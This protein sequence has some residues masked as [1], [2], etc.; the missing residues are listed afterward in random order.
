VIEI[1]DEKLLYQ[2]ANNLVV[3]GSIYLLF[4][5][6][7]CVLQGCIILLPVLFHTMHELEESEQDDPIMP[8]KWIYHKNSDLNEVLNYIRNVYDGFRIED[9]IDEHHNLS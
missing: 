5:S 4:Q 2:I 1:L 7:A 3:N 9:E 8:N 6:L